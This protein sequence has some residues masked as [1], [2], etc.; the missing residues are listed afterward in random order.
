[1]RMKRL[2][3]AK[4]YVVCSF[5]VLVKFFAYTTYTRNSGVSLTPFMS[6]RRVNLLTTRRDLWDNQILYD[7]QANSAGYEKL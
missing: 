4:L 1:M 7:D 6:E 5:H 2:K 3:I